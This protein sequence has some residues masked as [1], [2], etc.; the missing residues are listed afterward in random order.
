MIIRITIGWLEAKRADGAKILMMGSAVR[1]QC[2][3]CPMQ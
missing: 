3:P 1:Y 2:H